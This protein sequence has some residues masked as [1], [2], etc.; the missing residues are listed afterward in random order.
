MRPF[1]EGDRKAL[2]KD[3]WARLDAHGWSI[4]TYAAPNGWSALPGHGHQ[5]I[6]SFELHR[7]DDIMIRDPGRG[8]YMNTRDVGALAQNG[9]SISNTDPY[10]TNRAYYDD[11]FRREVGGPPP[12]LHVGADEAYVA[13]DGFARLPGVGRVARHWRLG[14]N[15]VIVEDEIAGTARRDITR[16][17]HTT[18]P[19]RIDGGAAVLGDRYRITADA[20]LRVRTTTCWIAYGEGVPA[21]CLEVPLRV[22]LPARLRMQIETI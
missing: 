17:L 18:L 16:R 22:K 20:P 5:D 3:G 7:G 11:E 9:I 19:V 1:A 13:F 2:A 14:T 8:T 21:T 12:E 10:P 6:G 4:L 15:A